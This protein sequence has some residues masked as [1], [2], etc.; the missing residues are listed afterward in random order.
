[1]A[2]TIN[3]PGLGALRAHAYGCMRGYRYQRH[4]VQ[5]GHVLTFG[6]GMAHGSIDFT[7]Q[8]IIISIKSFLSLGA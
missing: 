4:H 8:K 6:G 2:V 3:F 7:Y 5:T 1:M